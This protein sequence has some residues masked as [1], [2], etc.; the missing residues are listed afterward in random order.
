MNLARDRFYQ[1]NVTKQL[2]LFKG[3]P[4]ESVWNTP[5]TRYTYESKNR[6]YDVDVRNHDK[7]KSYHINGGFDGEPN[8]Y[9]REIEKHFNL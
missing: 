1:G 3:S 7:N 4:S 6:L 9:H 5:Y 2:T 8:K